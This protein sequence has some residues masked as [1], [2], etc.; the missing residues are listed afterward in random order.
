MAL[1]MW[2]NNITACLGGFLVKG[3]NQGECRG[4]ASVS[5]IKEEGII[6]Y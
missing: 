6:S 2:C 4:I 3:K 5:R 1:Y